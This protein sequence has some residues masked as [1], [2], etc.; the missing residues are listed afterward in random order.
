[1]LAERVEAVEFSDL[2]PPLGE[3]WYEVSAL[4]M[5]GNASRPASCTVIMGATP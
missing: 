1:V 5:A 3:L 4:D 2:D